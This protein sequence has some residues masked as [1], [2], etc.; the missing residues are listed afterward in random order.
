MVA[1]PIVDPV[2]EEAPA[3]VDPAPAAAAPAAAAPS[4]DE[5]VRAAGDAIRA[6]LLVRTYRVRGHLAANL[7][8][9]GLAQHLPDSVGH[10]RAHAAAGRF[11]RA[12]SVAPSQSRRTAMPSANS[13]NAGK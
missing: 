10:G 4:Q 2:H 7:D 12:Q 3:T 8:P 6:Q 13:R 9:L 5:I 11:P 1:A